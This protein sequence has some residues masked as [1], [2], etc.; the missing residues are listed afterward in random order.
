MKAFSFQKTLAALLVLFKNVNEFLSAFSVS[1]IYFVYSI[2]IKI[3]IIII[4]III[5]IRNSC[6]YNDSKGLHAGICANPQKGV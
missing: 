3:I 1:G 4:I 2:M 6:C 5:G